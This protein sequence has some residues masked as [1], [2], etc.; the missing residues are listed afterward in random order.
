MSDINFWFN[1]SVP[2]YSDSELKLFKAAS[3]GQQDIVSALLLQ[4]INPAV[5]INGFNSLHIAAKKNHAVIISSIL[6]AYPNLDSS[7][8]DDGRT[9]LMIAAFEG[10]T[11]ACTSIENHSSTGLLV[12]Q[13][14]SIVHF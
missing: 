13:A 2:A 1:D 5:R 4:H 12:D 11:E 14:V 6:N 3:S 10:N 8:T 9:A 7:V